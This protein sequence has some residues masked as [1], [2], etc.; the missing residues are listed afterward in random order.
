MA[1]HA[2]GKDEIAQLL[3]GLT[4]MRDNL[5]YVVSGV[6]GNAQGVASA[7]AEIALGNNDL[8]MR[9]EQ[10]ASALQEL[11]HDEVVDAFA[12]QKLKA[13]DV[14]HQRVKD[15]V[16]G[17]H[18]ME[19]IRQQA[20]EETR[21]ARQRARGL[22]PTIREARAIENEFAGQL[23]VGEVR[24]ATKTRA[25]SKTNYDAMMGDLFQAMDA[26]VMHD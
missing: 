21:A 9:T 6:R 16:L 2:R 13:A 8:S 3:S 22:T 7:S 24:G 4:V 15:A 25:E 12:F 20:I 18:R 1:I 26:E 5:A 19:L 23:M 10:Q 14:E 11:T 17:Y